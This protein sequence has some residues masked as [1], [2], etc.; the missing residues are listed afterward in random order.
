MPSKTHIGHRHL[1]RASIMSYLADPMPGTPSAG[2][3]IACNMAMKRRFGIDYKPPPNAVP[4]PGV[5]LADQGAA[6]LRIAP[7]ELP[8]AD[9]GH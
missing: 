9:G 1:D 6:Q 4:D 5:G 7:D 8:E 2:D 3:Y